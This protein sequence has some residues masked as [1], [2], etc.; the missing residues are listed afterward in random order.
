MSDSFR[1][2]GLENARRPCPSPVAMVVSWLCCISFWNLLCSVCVLVIQLCLTLCD[3]VDYSLP[4]SSV[5]GILQA[6]ILEQVVIPFSRGS[7]WHRDQTQVLNYLKSAKNVSCFMMVRRVVLFFQLSCMC[8]K[9]GN[10][11][12]N[13]KYSAVTLWVSHRGVL[14]LIMHILKSFLGHLVCA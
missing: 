8:M 11:W 5:H 9:R 7:S 12:E 2:H 14:D 3:P 13:N 6:R 4:G 1:L 10:W